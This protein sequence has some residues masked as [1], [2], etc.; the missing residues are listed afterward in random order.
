MIYH[1]H[2]GKVLIYPQEKHIR[3]YARFQNNNNVINKTIIKPLC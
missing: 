2:S 3:K 1:N